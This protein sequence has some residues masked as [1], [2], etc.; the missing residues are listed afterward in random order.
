[1]NLQY[2]AK[3]DIKMVDDAANQVGVDRNLFR[4]LKKILEG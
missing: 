2:F 4:E 3:R 1:M